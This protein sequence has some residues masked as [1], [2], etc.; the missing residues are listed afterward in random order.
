MELTEL[1]VRLI[2]KHKL[3][4]FLE[5]FDD[6]QCSLRI[7]HTEMADYDSDSSL[8]D[9]SEYTETGVLLGYATKEPTDDTIS[10]FGGHPVCTLLRAWTN[11]A[12][13]CTDMA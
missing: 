9:A 5:Q 2:D 10:H 12:D 4:H 3:N 6:G 1:S 7:K 8:E 11:F 13:N